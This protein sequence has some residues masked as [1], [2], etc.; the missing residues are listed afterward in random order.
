MGGWAICTTGILVIG[1]L[2]DVS[3]YYFYD[4]LGLTGGETNSGN[5]KPL[6]KNDAAV[7]IGAVV[8][9]VVMTAHLRDRHRDLGQAPAVHDPRAGGDPPV[10]RGSGLRAA[11]L[12]QG[13]G[14]VD[15]ARA[16]LAL[17][18]RRRVLGHVDRGPLG[19]LHL[20]GLG[21]RREPLGGERGLLAGARP[22]RAREHRDPAVHLR[23]RHRG[24]DRLRRPRRRS[25]SSTTTPAS[26]ARSPRDALGRR[27]RKAPRD[28][29][30]HLGHLLGAD[31]DPAGVA[32]VALDGGCR[33]V[34]EG[35]RQDPSALS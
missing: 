29:G 21:V 31:D 28:R 11:D 18:V 16:Q 30:D 25:S 5:P 26:W 1:S 20:L 23:G 6:F 32:H 14:V 7:A 2:A 35:L 24:P 15:H 9:I 8:I 34:A 3:A 17:P 27:P 19:R 22:G 12:R 13:A 4:L 33:R 10:L